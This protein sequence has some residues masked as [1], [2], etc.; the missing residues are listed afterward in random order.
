[1]FAAPLLGAV[2]LQVSDR[3]APAV[4]SCWR[5]STWAPK[6]TAETVTFDVV[7]MPTARKRSL[8][9]GAG[10]ENV[11]GPVPGPGPGGAR[12]P[13]GRGGGG[14]GRE[15][16]NANSAGGLPLLK[17]TRIPPLRG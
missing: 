17:K 7:E 4:A 16:N 6:V 9:A 12:G 15:K 11:G 3:T 13:S 5:V 1:M 8:P 10:N 2:R 14:A